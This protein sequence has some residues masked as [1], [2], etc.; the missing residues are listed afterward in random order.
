MTDDV[1]LAWAGRASWEVDARG[2]CP[3]APPTKGR[4]AFGNQLMGIGER[5]M[6]EVPVHR[7]LRAPLF[8]PH[9]LTGSKGSMALGGEREGQSPSHPLPTRATRPFARTTP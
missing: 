4:E 2:L 9:K 7:S 5:G 8:N 1:G 3:P 6:A